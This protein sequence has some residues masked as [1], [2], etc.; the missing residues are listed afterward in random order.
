VL[1]VKLAPPGSALVASLLP[2][3]HERLQSLAKALSEEDLLRALDLLTRAEGEL[4]S[5]P[6]ARVALDLVLLKLVQLR[7]LVPF[8]ELVARVER[9]GGA[10]AALAAPEPTAPR[11]VASARV[12]PLAS[13][14]APSPLPATKPHESGSA[15][16]PPAPATSRTADA[17]LQAM[18]GACSERPSLAAPLRSA[19]ARLEGETL[20]LEVA[21]DFAPFAKVHGDEYRDLTRAAAGRPLAVRVDVRPPTGGEGPA[22]PHEADL[23]RQKLRE[24]AAR[25]PAVQEALA[26]F[27]GR[28]VDVREAKPSRED[29]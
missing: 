14:A 3:E 22:P 13:P 1:L 12:A 20:V 27:D 19:Q 18:I 29:P 26:L 9:L 17:L 21:A 25:E 16:P 5:A 28:L 4:R 15:P 8:A 10:G 7:R 11:P 2:E 23:R 24:D 6:D